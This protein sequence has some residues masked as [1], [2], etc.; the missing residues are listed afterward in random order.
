[1]ISLLTEI[2]NWYARHCNGEW[3]HHHG[4]SIQSTDNPGWWVKIDLTG[5]PLATREFAVFTEGIDVGGHPIAARWLSCS[6]SDGL[7]NGAGDET[8][9]EELLTRFLAWA[10]AA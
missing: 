4:I 10:N 8:R 7:W 6:V 1:M 2:S 5:T 3:E 9:L